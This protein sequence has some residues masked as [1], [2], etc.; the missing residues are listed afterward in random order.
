MT[1]F[2]F[3]CLVKNTVPTSW[4]FKASTKL[5]GPWPEERLTH[6]RL[7]V[8]MW[9]ALG[10]CL[11]SLMTQYLI[12]CPTLK[13]VLICRDKG[14]V[15]EAMRDRVEI[16][17][18]GSLNGGLGGP[19]LAL[20]PRHYLASSLTQSIHRNLVQNF[21]S[22]TRAHIHC[23]TSSKTSHHQSLPFS[24]DLSRSRS[25]SPLSSKAVPDSDP[26]FHISQN[27]KARLD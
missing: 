27:N 9:R 18:I 12:F 26:A 8:M 1:N 3:L 4:S 13:I 15:S 11:F 23:T 19:V 14:N 20:K 6:V 5:R 21:R 25:H 17:A 16:E 7:R 24:L 22:F 2:L 10:P